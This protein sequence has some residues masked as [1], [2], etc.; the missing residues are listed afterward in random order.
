MKLD[1]DEIARQWPQS[2]DVVV[3]QPVSPRGE[4]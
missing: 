1:R 3:M 2:Q 4:G